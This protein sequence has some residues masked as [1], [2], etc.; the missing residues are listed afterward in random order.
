L[1][2]QRRGEVRTVAA[3]LDDRDL[4]ALLPEQGPLLQQRRQTLLIAA[5]WDGRGRVGGLGLGAWLR[6]LRHGRPS[7]GGLRG[8]NA[9]RAEGIIRSAG[10][11]NGSS[12][13]NVSCRRRQAAW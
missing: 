6:R 13:W 4:L 5:G 1:L 8:L 9:D 7:R 2:G 3:Q 12:P 10:Q 11:A